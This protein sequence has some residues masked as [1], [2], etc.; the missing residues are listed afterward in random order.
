M[1]L[2]IPQIVAG[3]AADFQAR[4]ITAPVSF[5]T[6]NVSKHKSATQVIVGLD[7]FDFQAPGPPNAPG[8]QTI[9]A[10]HAARS[11]FSR[12][13]TVKVWVYAAPDPNPKAP[14]RTEIA[15]QNAAALLHNAVAALYRLAHG[16]YA[17]GVGAGEWPDSDRVEG[18]MYGSL[19]I[20]KA[21]FWIPV[22]DDPLPLVMPDPVNTTTEVTWGGPS[23]DVVAVQ[24]P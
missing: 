16:S 9:N 17:L 2:S 10:T 24:T 23:G 12:V 3:V 14:N 11:L 15:Q 22:L 19:A 1:S 4:G 13:Q 5:G 21:Q 8:P 7:A 18:I 6:F 20:F